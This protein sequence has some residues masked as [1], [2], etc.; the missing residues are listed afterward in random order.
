MDGSRVGMLVWP[1]ST[2]GRRA[3][4]RSVKM[5]GQ[6]DLFVQVWP[7]ELRASKA[8]QITLRRASGGGRPVR[9]GSTLLR[10]SEAGLAGMV[11]LCAPNSP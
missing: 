4:T 1:R 3:R 11:R 6:Q 8:E 5:H 10:T 2:T 7:H 9:A